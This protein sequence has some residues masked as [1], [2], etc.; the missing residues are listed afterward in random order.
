MQ[1]F[2]PHSAQTAEWDP[3]GAEPSQLQVNKLLGVS[4]ARSSLK[5]IDIDI[6]IKNT[7]GSQNKLPCQSTE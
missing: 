6:S 3:L 1:T 4:R 2:R 5:I 7:F